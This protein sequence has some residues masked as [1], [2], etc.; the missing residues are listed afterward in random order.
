MVLP[1][2]SIAAVCAAG[3]Y[4]LSE[5]RNNRESV[6]GEQPESL[7]ARLSPSSLGVLVP[8]IATQ[9]DAVRSQFPWK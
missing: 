1:P 3:V 7:V 5:A 8:T 4:A 6:L 9:R 2:A